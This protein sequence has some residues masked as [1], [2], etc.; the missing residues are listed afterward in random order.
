MNNV[1]RSAQFTRTLVASAARTTTGVS[2]AVYL[3]DAPNGIVFVLGVTAAATDS[4]DTLDVKVQT[5]LDGS[6]WT[7]VV[8]FTQVLGNGGAKHH[9]AKITANGTQ[10]MFENGA[11]LSAGSVRNI[12][13]DTY[14]CA[15]SITD[16][17]TDN[18]SFTFSVNAIVC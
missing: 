1:A 9:V 12:L 11:S 5:T 13:G 6:T 2:D 14:R 10:A 16:A 8:A 15:W 3:Q 7:D 4:G 17:S 18:A